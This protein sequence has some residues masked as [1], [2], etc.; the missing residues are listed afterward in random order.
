MSTTIKGKVN[1]V[2]SSIHVYFVFNSIRN[3]KLDTLN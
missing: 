1:R 3:K 2:F